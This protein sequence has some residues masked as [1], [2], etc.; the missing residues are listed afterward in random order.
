MFTDNTE[1]REPVVK[2]PSDHVLE[3]LQSVKEDSTLNEV[4]NSML[5]F[6]ISRFKSHKS[7]WSHPYKGHDID[8][9]SVYP[10]H[11][12]IFGGKT[13]YRGPGQREIV[14]KEVVSEVLVEKV[15][16][17]IGVLKEGQDVKYLLDNTP[18]GYSSDR[19]TS[20]FVSRDRYGSTDI[21]TLPTDTNGVTV[22]LKTDP[23][24]VWKGLPIISFTFSEFAVKES[25]RNW[26]GKDLI[27]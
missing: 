18:V 3:A 25:V 2:N 22:D 16:R 7:E 27:E 14:G 23:S 9:V 6:A 21:M 17:K 26:A 11:E 12:S 4:D 24:N 1:W 20:P 8:A 10:E 15:L 5:D 13:L 19:M